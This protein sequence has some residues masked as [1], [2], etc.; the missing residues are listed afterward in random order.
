VSSNVTLLEVVD[1]RLYRSEKMHQQAL[2]LIAPLQT[3]TIEQ[4]QWIRIQARDRAAAKIDAEA[5]EAREKFQQWVEVTSDDEIV[6]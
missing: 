2:K 6:S 1:D 5:R 4:E 3:L